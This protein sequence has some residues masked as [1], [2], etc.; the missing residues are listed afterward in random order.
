MGLAISLCG[1]FKEKVWYHQCPSK[2]KSCVNTRLTDQGGCTIWYN[3]KQILGEIEEHLNI[4]VSQV[5]PDMKVPCDQFDGKVTYGQKKKQLGTGYEGHVTNLA[6][7]VAE[8]ASLETQAQL[9]YLKMRGQRL[10]S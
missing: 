2:G 10:R 1:C 9:A 7:A 8:L 6:P 3:E 5:E 4:I